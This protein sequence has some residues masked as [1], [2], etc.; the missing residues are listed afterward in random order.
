LVFFTRYRRGVF[1]TEM[2][3]LCEQLMAQVYT[4]FGATLAEFNGEEDH[5]H[6]LAA[7]PPKVALSHLVNSRKGGSSRRLRQD[8]VGRT[9]TGCE[10]QPVL[11]PVILRRI[12]RR[13]ATVHSPGLHHQPETTR[14]GK[15]SSLPART[16][17]QPQITDDGGVNIFHLT[18]GPGAELVARGHA[19]ACSVR[20]LSA[21]VA[22]GHGRRP[23]HGVG[24]ARCA[25]TTT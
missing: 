2:L 17:F 11:V 10:A 12:L 8:F 19:R 7:Y 14:P 13:P 4:G 5:V 6:L 22:V 1:N 23:V 3:N 24:T 15:A 18:G 16:G 9:N 21:I 25:L 20:E